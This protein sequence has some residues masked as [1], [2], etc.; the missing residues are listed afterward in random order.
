MIIRRMQVEGGFLDG[1]D[2]RFEPGL[3]VLIG[4]RGTGKSSIIELI[5]YCF[6]QPG[7]A[8]EEDQTRSREQAL[9]VL[10]DGQATL[11]IEDGENDIDISRSANAEPEG[12]ERGLP[13]PLI[14]SQKNVESI[15]LSSRGRLNIVDLFLPDLSV[16]RSEEHRLV[17]QIRSLTTEVFS[18]LREA[19]EISERLAGSESIVAELNR[20]EARAAE[21]S[22]SSSLLDAK[23]KQLERLAAQSANLAVRGDALR[24][25]LETAKN[26]RDEVERVKA[27]GFSLDDWPASAGAADILQ[28]VRVKL[29][30]AERHINAAHDLL[31]GSAED[32]EES[33]RAVEKER[34]PLEEQARAIRREVEGLK[35]GAGAAAR[36]LAGLR[37]KSTQLEALKALVGQRFERA[38]RVQ[39]Q[40]RALLEELDALREARCAERQRIA[41]LLTNNLS[42][43]IRVRIRQ[44]AQ[45]NEFVGAVINVLRGSGLRYNEL[46]RAIVVTMTPR[47]LIEAVEASDVQFISKTAKISLDRA[48]RITAQLRAA[49]SENI[50]SI[51]LEDAVDFELLDG[52]DF[53]PMDN[54]SVGQR[55]T[56]VLSILLQNPDR[57][58]IVDQPEDHLD[59]A[60]IVETLISA[61]RKR[62]AKGQIL[63]STHNAN[64]PVLGEAACVARLGSNG[65]RGFV[66]H[67]E[68]LDHPKTV[69]AITGVME[70]GIE[71]FRTRADFYR[72]HSNE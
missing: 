33:I 16:Q 1:L 54:L 26:Y 48:E 24:R 28:P 66:M 36:Q 38:A 5:R 67:A 42:P 23:Q 19:D 31:A 13:R 32:I 58:L 6:D 12:L 56:V 29:A 27:F 25:A 34:A 51:A 49:G 59:N 17:T 64:I 14:F 44:T 68:P 30:Q 35:E 55:C 15:G 69:A 4:G 18:L 60:F 45:V 50:I 71:A 37:E 62:S 65:R 8:D 10:Q 57:V 21:I 61:I 22:K 39:K 63:F 47:E 52:A 43:F 70:G 2:L 9:S 7:S 11:S 46:A 72:R 40:R 3:N 20:A 53:K 41:K